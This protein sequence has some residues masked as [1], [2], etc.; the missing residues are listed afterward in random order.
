MTYNINKQYTFSFYDAMLNVDDDYYKPVKYINLNNNNANYDYYES[1]TNKNMNV[2]Q[3]L[4]LIKPH[5]PDLIDNYRCK[6][7]KCSIQLS[8]SVNF[9][10]S[11]FTKDTRVFDLTTNFEE[12]DFYDDTNN[13]ITSLI[14]SLINDY[15]CKKGKC[16]L[17]FSHISLF[18]YYVHRIDNNL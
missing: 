11:K 15:K 2:K 14:S 9:L 8:V 16:G 3:Y 13:I 7:N 12:F 6:M 17:L 4:L 1:K 18:S 10:I 5:L